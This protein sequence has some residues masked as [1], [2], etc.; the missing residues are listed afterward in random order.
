M[1]T[2]LRVKYPLFLSYVN[3]SSIF[4]E[5]C[6][7]ILKYQISRKS[8]QWNPSCSM[9]RTDGHTY[10]TKPIVAFRTETQAEAKEVRSL[11]FK[12]L[13]QWQTRGRFISV[14]SVNG[15]DVI[16][17]KEILFGKGTS[18]QVQGSI[19]VPHNTFTSTSSSA[20]TQLQQA[21]SYFMRNPSTVTSLPTTRFPFFLTSH[22][23]NQPHNQTTYLLTN[24]TT[25]QTTNQ[26]TKYPTNQATYL[27][28]NQ[29]INH[30]RK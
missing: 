7:K 1:Y 15:I 14:R 24:Q 29:P 19:Y 18:R 21:S 23:T 10:M 5:N 27:P 2:G 20:L 30:S 17:V 28:T 3:E 12:S 13:C 25:N 16:S 8:V 4:L 26:P 6:R 9:R 22:S 11:T